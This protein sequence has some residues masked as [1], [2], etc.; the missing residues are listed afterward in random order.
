M[1]EL[2]RLRKQR[3]ALFAKQWKLEEARV[4]TLLA[5]RELE[6]QVGQQQEQEVQKKRGKKRERE[7]QPWTCA[8]NVVTGEECPV[9]E[10][11]IVQGANTRWNKQTYQTCKEC[12]KAI[13]KARK[14]LHETKEPVEEEEAADE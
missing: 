12:K 11:D 6:T 3:K 9:D 5:I 7:E 2:K 13:T 14:A 8:G 10:K 1:A 4:Q